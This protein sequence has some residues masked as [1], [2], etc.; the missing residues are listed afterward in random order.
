MAGAVDTGFI[1]S[2]WAELHATAKEFLPW[3]LVIP[4]THADGWRL[5]GPAEFRAVSDRTGDGSRGAAL[6]VAGPITAPMPGRVTAVNVAAGATVRRGD[7][8]MVLE[9]MK[10]E[11]AIA[12]PADGVV[13]RV[14]FAAGDLV[15]E[16]ALLL[17]MVPAP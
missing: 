2:H 16:G 3:L 17:E 8:L 1:A 6:A 14:C 12:A 15:D 9:A 4:G 7:V 11:H 13:S 10:M 5:N